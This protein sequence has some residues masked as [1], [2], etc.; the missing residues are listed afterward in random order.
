MT[1]PLTDEFLL[2]S[3]QP[4][5]IVWLEANMTDEVTRFTFTYKA[6]P[7]L[8]SIHP[9]VTIPRYA[10]GQAIFMNILKH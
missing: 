6:D 7:R 10:N 1:Q 8:K 5:K 3:E 4:V 2:D 9:D